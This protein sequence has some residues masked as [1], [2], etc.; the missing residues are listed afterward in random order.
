[1]FQPSQSPLRI[2]EGKIVRKD[3]TRTKIPSSTQKPKDVRL[4]VSS[5]LIKL[6]TIMDL[7]GIFLSFRKMQV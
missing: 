3:F 5:I 1:M 2:G 7:I 6:T 4:Y